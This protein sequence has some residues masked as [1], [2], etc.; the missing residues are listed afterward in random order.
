[1]I[2]P[3]ACVVAIATVISTMSTAMA[4]QRIRIRSEW[5]VLTATLSDNPAAR[6]LYAM[7][8][9]TLPMTDHLRQEKVGNLPKDLPE[10]PRVRPF[11]AGTLGIWQSNRFVLYYIGG[12]VPSP[13]IMIVGQ[14]V[15]DASAFNRPGSVTVHLEHLD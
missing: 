11:Q 7:L 10:I 15:G 9:L 1:M 14:V 5:G 4:E 12:E 3:V 2:R 8:P 6:A 13:G